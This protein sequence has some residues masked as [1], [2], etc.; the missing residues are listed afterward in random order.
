MWT[1]VG[2]RIALDWPVACSP[3]LDD[4]DDPPSL[5]D[6]DDD[7]LSRRD[8]GPFFFFF[9][10]LGPSITIPP[11]STLHRS[12]CCSTHARVIPSTGGRL[13]YR[14]IGEN[15]P[16][17]AHRETAFV[18][19]V[20]EAVSLYYNIFALHSGQVRTPVRVQPTMHAS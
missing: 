3:S 19:A 9:G 12:I 7:E 16:S 5:D 15:L 13:I 1:P 18:D 6:D 20:D 14:F 10:N 4:D 2:V 8:D 17:V 11:S